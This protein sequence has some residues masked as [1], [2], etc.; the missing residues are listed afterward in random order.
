MTGDGAAGVYNVAFTVMAAVYLLPSVIYQKFLLPKMH[1]WANSDRARFYKVYRQGNFA[2]LLLGVAAMLAIW[3]SA[4]WAIPLFFGKHYAEAVT[5]LNILAPCAPLMF[6]AFSFGG[7][8]VTQ[9]NMRLKVKVMGGVALI[10]VLM[11]LALIPTWGTKGVA[12]STVLSCLA[13]M[14]AY[15]WCAQKIVFGRSEG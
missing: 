14:V 13:L 1:R 11:N 8:L 6:L 10:N 9:E 15:F 7:V 3:L 12:I 5:L 4:F 2:M